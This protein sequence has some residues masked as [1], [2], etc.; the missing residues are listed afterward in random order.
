MTW[1]S[2]QLGRI[3]PFA[4]LA[5]T[6][7]GQA[8][9]AQQGAL[10]ASTQ[11]APAAADAAGAPPAPAPVELQR[12]ITER[13]EACGG[14]VAKDFGKTSRADFN[15]DGKTDYVLSQENFLCADEPGGQMTWGKGGP[16]YEFLVSTAAGYTLDEGFYTAGGIS[17]V[18]RPKGDVVQLEHENMSSEGCAGAF[19]IT[20]SWT[21]RKMD[22]TDRRNAK[23]QKVDEGGCAA[24]AS[25]DLPI[26]LGYYGYDGEGFDPCAMTDG[27][28]IDDKYFG[29]IDGDY[30]L[31]PVRNL[32]N[33][34]YRLG[35]SYT[36]EVTAPGRFAVWVTGAPR[37]ETERR[38][39][40]C[41]AKAPQ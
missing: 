20:W 2:H 31:R 5:C 10:Q 37:G 8:D 1:T 3:V 18:P 21:G 14:K 7:C 27:V 12:L 19:T 13:R 40:W 17:I 4:L 41:A 38:L 32:G 25:G 11:T 30:P 24:A 22:V 28:T 36:I 15:G 23:G 16:H 29:D 33:G 35:D 6:A 9:Q 34:Q 26:K 39:V